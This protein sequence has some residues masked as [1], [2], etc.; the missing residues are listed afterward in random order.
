MLCILMCKFRGVAV[1]DRIAERRHLAGGAWP[2]LL[3]VVCAGSRPPA[4]RG[5]ARAA[6]GPL[7]APVAN[8]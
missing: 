7:R 5:L 1:H 2:V 3:A 6:M 8:L 4:F